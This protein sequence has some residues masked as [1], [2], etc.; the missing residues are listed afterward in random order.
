LRGLP[1]VERGNHAG[2]LSLPYISNNLNRLRNAKYLS[3]L[4]INTAYWQVPGSKGGRQKTAFTVPNNGLFEFT[5]MPFGLHNAPTTGQRLI[6]SVLRHELKSFVF[7][8]LKDIVIVTESFDRH[9]EVLRDVLTRLK[10]EGLRL[11]LENNRLC[12][13]ELRYLG[14]VVDRRGLKVDPEK[15]ASILN[16]PA[17]KRVRLV[18]RF[19]GLASSY[20][21]FV[22]NFS[23][24]LKSLTTLL[25][26]G[27][28][29]VWACEQEAD[30]RA[31]KELLG[32]LL[33]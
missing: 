12:L 14:Y 25:K 28:K 2:R 26:K 3:T 23:K 1:E 4:D 5:R 27:K 8:Y 30:F 29:F 18:C 7:V 10:E 20:R 33:F 9:L 24:S 19:R 11:N 32:S 21:I 6:D 15:V 22:P 13:P 17:P 16:Y 31:V